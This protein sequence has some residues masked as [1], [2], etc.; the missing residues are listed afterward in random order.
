MTPQETAARCDWVLSGG[1]SISMA[2]ARKLTTSLQTAL[3]YLGRAR[4]YVAS[5]SRS[6]ALEDEMRV[7]L[8]GRAERSGR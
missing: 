7:F 2:D 1:R 8:G 3:G 5:R 6:V 4:P